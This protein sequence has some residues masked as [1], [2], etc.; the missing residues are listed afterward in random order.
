MGRLVL[1]IFFILFLS[2]PVKAEIVTVYDDFGNSLSFDQPVKKIIV[3]SPHLTELVF[4]AGAQEKLVATV[5]FADYPPAAGQIP[6]IGSYNT[7]DVEKIVAMKP[8]IVLVWLS[9]RGIEML[10]R[11]KQLGL[12]VY[13]SEPRKLSDISR[14]IRDIG[15]MSGSNDIAEKRAKEFERAIAS[16][17]GK[18]KNRKRVRLFYQVWRPPLVTING[19]QLINQVFNLCGGENIF[20]DLPALAP[21]ISIESLLLENPDVILGGARQEDRQRWLHEWRKWPALNAVKNN[22]LFFV[23][24]DLLSRQTSRMLQGAYQVC[25]QLEQ[26][27]QKSVKNDRRQ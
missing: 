24:P 8:D 19:K 23:N 7:W 12:R 27:R 15:I 18:Y 6:R 16:L 9:A 26:V 11:L 1:N 2:A 5:E 3:L 25:D 17:K 21:V 14:T 22:N 13:V 20:A 10:E 4:E